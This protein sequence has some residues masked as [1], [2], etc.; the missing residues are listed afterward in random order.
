MHD[1]VHD[2]ARQI[3]QDEFVSE[4]EIAN[5]INRCRYVSL[6]SCTGKLFDKVRALYV[7]DRSLTFDKTMN[8]QCC[9]RTITLK[10]ISVAS[11]HIFVSK[12]E[13]LGYLEIS[14]VNCEALPEAISHCWNLQAIYVCYCRRLAVLPESIGKLKKLRTLELVDAQKVK[15]LPESIGDCDNLRSLHIKSCGI[16]DIPNSI[17]KMVNFRVLQICTYL[18]QLPESIGKLC[19]LRAILLN[20]CD[21]LQHLPQCITSL[22]H[23][24]YVDLSYCSNLV[25]L[26]E[27]IGNLKKLKVLNL[28]GCKN[29]CCLPAG[30]GQLTRLQQLGLFVIGDS[31]KHARISELENLG[32]LSGEL[33][34]ENIKY[35]KDRSDAEKARLKKKDGIQKLSL[36]WYSVKDGYRGLTSLP[37]YMRRLALEELLISGNPE[38]LRRCRE[39]VGEDWHLV[40]HIPDL[41]LHDQRNDVVISIAGH[42]KNCIGWVHPRA[43]HLQ[44]W[45]IKPFGSQNLVEQATSHPRPTEADSGWAAVAGRPGERQRPLGCPWTAINFWCTSAPIYARGVQLA[46]S[47]SASASKDVGT[48][49]GDALKNMGGMEAALVCS[50]LKTVGMTL[51]PLVIKE[52]SSIAGVKKD[53][54]ELQDLARQINNWLQAVGDKAISNELSCSWLKNLKDAAY[55]AEDL[56][57]EFHI[58]AEKYEL[59]ATVKNAM[60]RYLWAKPKSVLREKVTIAQLKIICLDCPIQHV[61][62]TIGEVPQ[63]TIVDE[64]SIFGRDREKDWLI[65]ELLEINVQQKVKIVS[66]IGLG[67][68]GKTTIA[69]LIF[70]DGNII[71]HFEVLLWVHVSREFSVEK[72]VEKLFE[73]IAGDKAD[74]LPLQRV[75]GTISDKL[76]GK[77]FL[78]VLDDVWTEDRV[79]WERFMVHLKSGAPGSSILLTTHSRKV[80]VAVDST[81]TYDLP[82]LSGEDSWNVFQ[83]CF[84]IAMKYLDP[85]FQQIGIEIVNKCGGVPLAVKV[86]AGVLHGMKA[87]EERQSIR[88]RNVIDVE[89]DERRVFSCL[90]LSYFHL[91]HHLKH[92][93]VHCSIFPRGHVI[94]RHHLIAQWIAHGFVPAIQAQQPEDIGIGY[95]DSLLKVGLLQVQDQRSLSGD[96]TCKMHDLV[97]DLARQILQDEFVSEIEITDRIKRCR[98]VSLT[99]CTGKLDSKIFDKVRALYIFGRSLTFDKTMN[100]QCCVRT[101]TL[102]HISVASLHIFVSKFE[103]LGYLEISNAN[104]EVLLETISLCWNLQAIYVRYCRRLAVV[105][106]SIG[107]LKKLRTLELNDALKVKI[108]P[109]SIGDCENLRSLYIERC[110][111]QDIPNSIGKIIIS[112]NNCWRLQHLPHCIT[113]LSHLEYVDLCNCYNLVEFPKGIWNL[114]KLKVLNLKKCD[115]LCGLPAGCGQL[116]RLQQLGLFIIGDST[117]HARISELENLD[118]LNGELRIENIKYVKDP[119]DAEKA[120]LMEKD[121]IWKLSLDWYSVEGIQSSDM[122]NELLINMEK[123]LHLLNCLEPPSKIKELRIGGY[124]GLQLPCWMMKKVDSY[125]LSDSDM[126]NPRNPSQFCRLTKL[127]ME[128]LPNLEHLLGP[129]GLPEIKTLEWR[130]MPKLL[131]LLTTTTGFTNGEEEDGM[132]YCFPGLSTLVISDCPKLSVKPYF[133]PFLQ[134]LTLEGSS[135]H[136][137]LSGCFFHPRH[138]GH[139]HGEDPSSSS[140]IVDVKYPHLMKLNLSRLIGSS[141]VWDVL[142]HLTGLH[143]LEIS[144]FRDL[145]YLPESMKYLTCLRRLKIKDCD[146]LCVL[147]E[148]LGELESLL[149]LLIEFLPIKSIPSQIQHL[150]SLESLCIVHC[151]ALHQ[152]PEQLGEICS[153]HDLEIFLPAL[154]YLPESMQRL[155]SLQF[156]FLSQC[157]ALAQLPES[158]GEL[159]ALRRFYIQRCTGL[160]SLPHSMRRLKLEKLRIGGNPELVRRCREGVGEDWLLISH[161]PDLCLQD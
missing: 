110:G 158:L 59:K 135:E 8:K 93:F 137:L 21:E 117:K 23:L 29:L 151:N 97:H 83:Q 61:R 45:A 22:S 127:V 35:V 17:G 30:C 33:R 84:G 161:I 128:N 37:H 5:Q 76:A 25:E 91:P 78:A 15:I 47:A 153:P 81:C 66:V 39:G 104:C 51:A 90:W 85:E 130:R 44:R 140:Y 11:L 55:D 114:R 94:N 155:T 28:K 9:I 152:L 147:P 95:F 74:H 48:I 142:E 13:H 103:D 71:K 31:T 143:A 36:D 121:G 6:T 53:L 156:L 4:I 123:P 134:S 46:P 157:K 49:K 115:K 10:N 56:I 116:T 32:Q 154:T 148:W 58:E 7:S 126:I 107:K 99:S 125:S 118:K 2:L 72:L 149:H 80:A 75:S 111:I 68:S 50:I 20:G 34:I 73:A 16:K 3:L 26:P 119:S 101:I 43:M 132:Q 77:R 100:K 64:T 136:L 1:L 146:N 57:H 159:S 24:E 96:V 108:L 27:G 60:L 18:H 19:N 62:K 131:E 105:P 113:S 87:I 82:F 133:P 42:T 160:A 141:S 150:T 52:F 129:V 69:K 12:Y 41:E 106:E 14:N 138:A 70:N 139:A 122:Q 144:H 120:C 112:L 89:D 109:Q 92:C 40:S 54:E 98:Y 65:S 63:W 124:Q 88:D 67:G 145:N 102:T 79:D 86:I 38:L